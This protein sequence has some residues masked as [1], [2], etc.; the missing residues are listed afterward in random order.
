MKNEKAWNGEFSRY[1]MLG[2]CNN[3]K[4]ENFGCKLVDIYFITR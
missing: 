4:L 3:V 2:Y 1:F